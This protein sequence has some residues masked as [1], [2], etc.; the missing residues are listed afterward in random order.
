[1]HA[2]AQ[3]IRAGLKLIATKDEVRAG[4]SVGLPQNSIVFS[5]LAY[6]SRLV[7]AMVCCDG[8]PGMHMKNALT[9]HCVNPEKDSELEASCIPDN[10]STPVSFRMFHTS[11]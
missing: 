1:M 9:G 2:F 10:R 8:N 3:C 7:S 4:R 5:T 11:L 6:L